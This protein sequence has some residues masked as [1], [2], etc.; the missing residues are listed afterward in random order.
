MGRITMIIAVAVLC[1]SSVITLESWADNQ[2]LDGKKN[3]VEIDYGD[4]RPSR[5]FEVPWVKDR[6]VLE[7]LLIVATVETHPV[8][9]YVFVFSIDGV[10]GKRG[11]MAWYYTVD[12]KSPGK[13]AYSNV[14][15]D[16]KHIKWVYKKDVCSCKVDGKPNLLKKGDD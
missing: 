13:L 14:L 7:V 2:T 1:V 11:E 8:G 6:T 4:I 5:T 9:Q 12:G 15:D 10:E 16:A 3:V